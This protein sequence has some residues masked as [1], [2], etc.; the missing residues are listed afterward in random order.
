MKNGI[1]MISN[2]S[3][4]VNSLSAT[5]STGTCV[6]VNRKVRTVRPSEMEIGMPVS[7]RTSSREKMMMPLMVGPSGLGGLGFFVQAVH[8]A[9]V[10][11]RQ[12]TGAHE[13]QA[14]CRKRKHISEEPSGM[15]L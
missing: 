11:V 12:L 14:T 10:V 13:A 9:V 5:D 4:P 15:A 8:M 1:A 6:M 3:M 2:F 7:I